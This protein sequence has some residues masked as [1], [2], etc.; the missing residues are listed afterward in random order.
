MLLLLLLLPLASLSTA[1]PHA[2]PWVGKALPRSKSSS[3]GEAAR[4]RTSTIRHFTLEE[5]P[6]RFMRDEVPDDG[7]QKY[8]AWCEITG[9]DKQV[10]QA[11]RQQLQREHVVWQRECMLPS[12]KEQ[13]LSETKLAVDDD[14]RPDS[15]RST[16]RILWEKKLI[17]PGSIYPDGMAVCVA[18]ASHAEFEAL[19]NADPFI[20]Q[21]VFD[22]VETFE[23]TRADEPELRYDPMP[24]PYLLLC[25]DKPGALET[26]KATRA[27]HLDYLR[28]SE[29]VGAA[30][31]ITAIGGPHPIGSLVA[32]WGEDDASVEAWAAA[33]PYAQAGVFEEVKQRAYL[34]SLSQ[35]EYASISQ[36]SFRH[37]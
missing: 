21:G 35:D 37:L 14:E 22:S 36:L 16:A 25:K 6:G 17:S 26:R 8:V 27:K 18:A 33:D 10:R 29:R 15:E 20:A 7:L 32:L 5:A 23:W 34:A 30:G 31:P 13:L 24:S 3:V 4:G 1:F 2:D 12:Q 9:D 11:L 28:A 19:I